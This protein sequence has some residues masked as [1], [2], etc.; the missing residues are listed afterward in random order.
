MRRVREPVIAIDGPAGAG[1]TTVA[2]LLAQHLGYR[3]VPTG[4]MYRAVALGIMRGGLAPRDGPALRAYLGSLEV[5]VAGGRVFL[6]GE[7]VTDAIGSPDVARTTSDL[8]ALAAVR[9]KVTP[10]QRREAA[11]GGVVL[12]GRDTGTVVCPDA[13]VKFFLTAS[14]EARARRRHAELLAEGRAAA[15]ATVQEEIHVR[16]EQDATRELAPLRKAP[17]AIEVDT[18]DLAIEQVVERLLADVARRRGRGRAVRPSRLYAA[19]R[20]LAA[21][22]MRLGWRLEGRDTPHVPAAGPVL[23]VANHS[24]FLDPPAIGS[25]APRQL[26]F[27]AKEALFAI[28]LFGRIIRAVNARPVRRGGADPAALRAG[29]RVLEDGGALLVFPEGSRGTE[30]VLRPPK[31]GAAMLAVMTGAPVVPVYVSGTGR[32]WPMGRL[33]PRPGKVV[34]AFGPPLRFA[35]AARGTGRKGAY[36]RASREMMTA[37]ARLGETVAADGG[38]RPQ[39]IAVQGE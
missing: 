22:A 21:A 19:V 37:I 11:A 15:L 25:C 27:L 36:E 9:E 7:D 2:R 16:D 28:P 35:A 18:S 31:P 1:K 38:I 29:L 3:L 32:A 17:D 8:T 4:I 12:E 34:V 20:V 14:L 24:S 6:N 23:F 26:H 30:G 33:L 39:R 10:L 5:A 13:E